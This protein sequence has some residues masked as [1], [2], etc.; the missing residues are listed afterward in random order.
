MKNSIL[1]L[2]F[3]YFQ[4]FVARPTHY[5]TERITDIIQRLVTAGLA[6]LVGEVQCRVRR[7]GEGYGEF[8]KTWAGDKQGLDHDGHCMEYKEDVYDDAGCDIINDIE[9][10]QQALNGLSSI[11]T[12]AEF[13]QVFDDL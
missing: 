6:S 8:I 13:K 10:I 9:R 1:Y 4:F 7:N 12:E 2:I 11:E 3:L 5:V